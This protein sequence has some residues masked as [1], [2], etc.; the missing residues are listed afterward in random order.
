MQRTLFDDLAP[1]F[2]G[3]TFDHE[4]DQARLS[5]QLARVLALMR[6]QHWRTLDEIRA[7]VGGSE[8]AISARLRDLRK[9]KFGRYAVERRHVHDGLFE[10]RVRP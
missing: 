5:G 1:A 6:D 7:V 2:D 8:A 3:E 10:Y 4:R 9:V